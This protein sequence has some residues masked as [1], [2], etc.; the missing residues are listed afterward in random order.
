MQTLFTYFL[1]LNI[2]LPEDIQ[3]LVFFANL[4][5]A[6]NC[7]MSNLPEEKL[8]ELELK[9]NQARQLVIEMLLEAGSGTYRRL[10]GNGRHFYRFLFPH[11]KTR[12]EKS[13]LAGPRQT[14]S[15]QRTYLPN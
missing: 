6:I 10:F 3:H 4:I 5:H 13:R 9:A 8:K 14:N 7:N 12:S 11:L 1:T 2:K 15:F